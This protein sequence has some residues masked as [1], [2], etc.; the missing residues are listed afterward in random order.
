MKTIR[1]EEPA[2][3]YEETD[4]PETIQDVPESF[5][6]RVWLEEAARPPHR[7]PWRGHITHVPTG[8]RKYVEDLQGIAAFIAS[9]LDRM[10]ARLQLWWRVRQWW[11][12]KP[13]SRVKAKV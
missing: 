2:L 1:H 7:A 11:K 10:Q 13:S 8:D 3:D 5:I 6:V 4:E 12:R 9:Y